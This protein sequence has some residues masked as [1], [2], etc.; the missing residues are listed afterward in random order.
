MHVKSILTKLL[1]GV[2]HQKRLNALSDVTRACFQARQLS[3]TGLGRAIEGSHQERSGIRKS[4]RLIGNEKLHAERLQ[5]YQTVAR[6]LIGRKK[7][8]WILV[9]WSGIPNSRNHVLRAAL[10]MEGRALSLYEEVH[11]EKEQGK[12]AIHNVFLDRLK[13]VLP[14]S[15][16]PIVVTDAGFHSVWFQQVRK[17]GW[18][19][20]GRVRGVTLY[21]RQ[22]ESHWQPLTK[23]LAQANK[24][25]RS[26]GSV[27]F[28]K[29]TPVD[30]TL[31]VFKAPLKGRV[32]KNKLGQK[33]RSSNSYDYAKS[34][35][36]GWALVTSLKGRNLAKR[37]VQIYS[38]RMQIEEGF[39]DLKSSTFGFGF[40]QSYSRKIYRI[41]NLLLVAMLASLAAYMTGW[42]AEKQN[43]QYQFQANSTKHRRVLSLFYLGCRVIRKQV[44]LITVPL[45]EITEHIAW[46][47]E[48]Y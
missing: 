16:Q 21:R 2:I 27:I 48:E 8:P 23:A 20:V 9:D 18:D 17:L 24:T 38:A 43:L 4:D 28:S 10:V 31:C 25:A 32:C 46:R 13:H 26:L 11:S 3:V 19:Y 40:E 29:L 45:E 47:C 41:E 14:N 33:R 6:C 44:K 36:E 42:I 22:G 15:C 37:V 5:L 35:R 39:R 34:V 7:R 12:K 30:C 1:K